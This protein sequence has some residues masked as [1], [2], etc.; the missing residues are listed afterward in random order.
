MRLR[1]KAEELIQP[2]PATLA[3]D[4]RARAWLDRLIRHG[5]WITFPVDPSPQEQP[6]KTKA[7]ATRPKG[8]KRMAI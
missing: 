4:A 2:D 6:V 7:V 8:S 1:V 5:E 3:A